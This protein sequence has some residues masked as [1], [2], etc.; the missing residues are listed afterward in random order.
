[1]KKSHKITRLGIKFIVKLDTSFSYYI[2][3]YINTSIISTL[4]FIFIYKTLKTKN[5]IK[6]KIQDDSGHPVF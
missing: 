5:L 6:K 3:N 1:M 4:D 2:I